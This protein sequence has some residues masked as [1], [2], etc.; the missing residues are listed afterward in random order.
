[1]IVSTDNSYEKYYV[2]KL[3][4]NYPIINFF[5]RLK[6]WFKLKIICSDILINYHLFQKFKLIGNDSIN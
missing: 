5:Y 2:S 3:I 6:A 1:M 4:V